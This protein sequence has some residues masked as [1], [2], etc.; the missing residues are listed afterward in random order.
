M[1]LNERKANND[2]VFPE[3]RKTPAGENAWRIQVTVA[4]DRRRGKRCLVSAY[5]D[6]NARRW[7]VFERTI[8]VMMVICVASK[9]GGRY[10]CKTTSALHFGNILGEAIR[11]IAGQPGPKAHSCSQT[12]SPR[13][14]RDTK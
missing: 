11:I 13:S 3:S 14:A 12:Y 1:P 9:C 4:R 8:E 6:I 2:S 5:S 10:G 7:K